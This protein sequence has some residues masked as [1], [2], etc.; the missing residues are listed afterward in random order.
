M[1]PEDVLTIM[2]I[3][4]P[5]ATLEHAK[6]FI[7]IAADRGLTPFQEIWPIFSETKK[8]QGD[9]WVV[10]GIKALTFKEHYSVQNRW[11]QKSGGYSVP[12]RQT[13]HVSR[14]NRYGK[15]EDGVEVTV[16]ILTNRDYA[17]LIQMA[18]INIP[19]W[20]FNE[21][22]KAFLHYATA[23]V[24]N[25]HSAP[26]GWS[27]ADVA[28][29]RAE[30]QALKQAFGKEPSQSREIYGRAIAVD[31]H[32]AAALMYSPEPR[33][34]LPAPATPIIEGDFTP[35]S[36]PEPPPFDEDADAEMVAELARQAQAETQADPDPLSNYDDAPFTTP[37]AAI[38]WGMTSG[39]FTHGQHAKNAYNKLRDEAKPQDARQMAQL[40][41]RDVAER[42]RAKNAQQQL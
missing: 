11:A 29:K 26:A 33:A 18:G 8:K 17:A 13:E 32:E 1:K 23:F 6:A 9:E 22:R 2:Q 20:D 5:L 4:Q 16:G 19:G 21:E 39:A 7:A 36:P 38:Q 25:T 34:A 3:T 41:R 30:E 10:T 37:E 42:L 28:R 35:P 27:I 15:Q 12:F 40:W 31:A 24:P 14:K